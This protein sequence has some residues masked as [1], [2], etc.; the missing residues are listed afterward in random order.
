MY[1]TSTTAVK[2]LYYDPS[3]HGD[4]RTQIFPILPYPIPSHPIPYPSTSQST[5]NFSCPCHSPSPNHPTASQPIPLHYAIPLRSP[6]PHAIDI[7]RQRKLPIISPKRQL[8]FL[9]PCTF[10]RGKP[11]VRDSSITIVYHA[12]PQRPHIRELG[13]SLSL[14]RATPSSNECPTRSTPNSAN[15]MKRLRHAS[16]CQ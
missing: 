1:I 2:N 6:Y 5:P 15:P 3:Q 9:A 11:L 4:H 10:L 16:G 13:R 12:P 8:F 7:P 14:S